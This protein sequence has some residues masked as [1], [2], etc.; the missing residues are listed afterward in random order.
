VQK[1]NMEI[2]TKGKKR[3]ASVRFFYYHELVGLNHLN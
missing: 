2:K 3:E 1:Q